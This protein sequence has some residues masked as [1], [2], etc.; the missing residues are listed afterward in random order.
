MSKNSPD[1][2]WRVFTE[3]NSGKD[4]KRVLSGI[5]SSLPLSIDI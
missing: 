4:V 5:F 1:F 3:L 2:I